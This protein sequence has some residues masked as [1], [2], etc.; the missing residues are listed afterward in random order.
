MGSCALQWIGG[1]PRVVRVMPNTPCLVG[2]AAS[3][4]CCG[5]WASDH[6]S[7]TTARIFGAVGTVHKVTEA[8]M[9]G[10]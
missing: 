5:K 10:A 3:G 9:D 8:Q 6:D 4:Y 7:A 2:E 1:S